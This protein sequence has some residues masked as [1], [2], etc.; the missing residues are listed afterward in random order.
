MSF[1]QVEQAN[2]AAADLL[3]LCAF[4]DPDAIPEEI[5]TEG[6]S[7]LGP[8]L[9]PVAAD[10]YKLNEAIEE[11]RRF[12]LIRRN[13]GAKL[14]NIHRLVQA[15]IRD[16]MD[17]DTQQIWA[18]RTVRAVN[19]VFPEVKVETW[20]Q[21]LRCLPHALACATLIEQ[22][23]FTFTEAAKLLDKAASYLDDHAQFSQAESLYKQALA[24]KEKVLGS[25]HADTGV[26]LNNLAR[27]YM[28]QGQY[29]QAEPLYQRALA[30]NE[31][32]LSPDHLKL[33]L[34][35]IIWQTSTR[36]RGSMH[37]LNLFT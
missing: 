28:N 17:A 4:L 14:L 26:S 11:L 36:I 18:E 5:I 31:K 25:E 19:Q 3:L 2:S 35:S 10:P 32:A 29:A 21:C 33:P 13:P 6:A 30:I 34:P 7:E 23:E 22:Y 8:T 15:V 16:G 12:S 1:Q 37:K 9:G 27:C 20:P 24:I